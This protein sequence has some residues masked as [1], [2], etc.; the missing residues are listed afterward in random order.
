[1]RIIMPIKNQ[2]FY[3]DDLDFWVLSQLWLCLWTE[4]GHWNLNPVVQV[5]DDISGVMAIDKASIFSFVF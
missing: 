5:T 2:V 1:M 4:Y 3:T